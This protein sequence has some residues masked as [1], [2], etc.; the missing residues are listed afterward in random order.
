ML[1]S[2]SEYGFCTN[3]SAKSGDNSEKSKI[4]F[5]FSVK[6]RPPL[7]SLAELRGGEALALLNTGPV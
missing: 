2:S 3:N 5:S 4:S 6:L 7:L 1:E